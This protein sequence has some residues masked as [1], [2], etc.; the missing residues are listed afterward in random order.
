MNAVSLQTTVLKDWLAVVSLSV[1]FTSESL[2]LPFER[3][4]AL[5]CFSAELD[6]HGLVVQIETDIW[7][8]TQ[9]VA[10]L[11]ATT[12]AAHSCPAE[13]NTLQPPEQDGLL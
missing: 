13:E 6:P 8:D 9:C 3:V 11:E 5:R 12:G 2:D 1:D 4:A 10:T 7:L